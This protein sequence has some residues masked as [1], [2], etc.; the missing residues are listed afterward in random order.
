[1]PKKL[2]YIL[3]LFAAFC[4]F[5]FATV[6][7]YEITACRNAN[8]LGLTNIRQSQ[9]EEIAETFND[10]KTIYTKLKLQISDISIKN[11]SI[12]ITDIS[13]RLKIVGDEISQLENELPPGIEDYSMIKA[14]LFEIKKNL[15]QIIV[16]AQN[17]E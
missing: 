12:Q 16:I 11:P 17:Y 7:I 4:F 6:T 10:I 15:M 5:L 2:V 3:P 13:S 9:S 8:I 14:K 1:M